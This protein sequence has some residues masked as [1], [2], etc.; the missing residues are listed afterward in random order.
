MR[1]LWM[2]RGALS[3]WSWGLAYGPRVPTS[4]DLFCRSVRFPVVGNGCRCRWSG[5]DGGLPGSRLETIV[6]VV[7]W[8]MVMMCEGNEGS[9]AVG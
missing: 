7:G 8:E 2:G 3:Y 4:H 5:G 6:L 9:R 1:M